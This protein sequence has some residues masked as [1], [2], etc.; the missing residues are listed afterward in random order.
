MRVFFGGEELAPA[1]RGD[2]TLDDVA[3]RRRL[4]LQAVPRRCGPF[5]FLDLLRR[6]RVAGRGEPD[7]CAGSDEKKSAAKSVARRRSARY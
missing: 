3:A 4:E 5:G 2:R 1:M 7:C 6:K